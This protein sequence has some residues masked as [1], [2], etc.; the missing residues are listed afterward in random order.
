MLVSRFR[1]IAAV[2][3]SGRLIM[4]R[5]S[6]AQLAEFANRNCHCRRTAN[7]GLL[8]AC[9]VSLFRPIAAVIADGRLIMACFSRAQLACFDQSQLSLPTDG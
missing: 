4:A 3:A 7:Y 6:R 9:T 1:P 8:F 2:I 5:F